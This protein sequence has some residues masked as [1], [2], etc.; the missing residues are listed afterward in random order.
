MHFSPESFVGGDLTAACLSIA[1]AREG[2]EIGTKPKSLRSAQPG[3]L[4][5]I[6]TKIREF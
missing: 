1:G 4:R 6:C 5:E 3:R 2:R